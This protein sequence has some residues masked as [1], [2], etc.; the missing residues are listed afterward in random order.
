MYAVYYC[1]ELFP[2]SQ[3]SFAHSHNKI[4]ILLCQDKAY[5]F[6]CNYKPLVVLL[7]WVRSKT[8]LLRAHAR[9]PVRAP[10]PYL[11]R[12]G[13]LVRARFS[14]EQM[15]DTSTTIGFAKVSS[16]EYIS[17]LSQKC[18]HLD[19]ALKVEKVAIHS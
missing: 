18:S 7:S 1:N 9:E 14:L 15:S 12:R 3:L 2:H 11:Q 4:T 17:T 13:E 8:N 19:I 10:R 6:R 16:F 5:G